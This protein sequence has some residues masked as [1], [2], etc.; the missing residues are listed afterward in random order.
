MTLSEVLSQYMAKKVEFSSIFRLRIAPEFYEGW[1]ESL[2]PPNSQANL[3][4]KRKALMKPTNE[5]PVFQ[6]SGD[7]R[8]HTPKMSH[9]ATTC[10]VIGHDAFRFCVGETVGGHLPSTFWQN[11]SNSLSNSASFGGHFMGAVE[12]KKLL[13][14]KSPK[15]NFTGV[16]IA[17]V[18]AKSNKHK[19]I[20][21]FVD[22]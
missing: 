10:D 13:P 4:K 21:T 7:F 2:K 1:L 11:F 6:N 19:K 18:K 8:C 14:K 3:H 16:K 22:L 20:Y 15:M 5:L 9:Y 12:R 17:W